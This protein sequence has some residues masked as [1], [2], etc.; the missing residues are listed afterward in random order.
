MHN[1]KAST[2]KRQGAV[3]VVAMV[4]LLVITAIIGTM[5]RGTLRNHRQLRSEKDRRQAELLLD[6]GVSRASKRLAADPDY[7]KETWSLPPDAISGAGE[8]RVIIE[9]T[10]TEAQESLTARISAEYPVGNEH[11]VRRS[12]TIQ[13][14]IQ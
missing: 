2:T 11:S 14:P 6:A 10:G 13:L 3:L 1:R 5:I 7:R 4:C 9:L 12:R 8:G